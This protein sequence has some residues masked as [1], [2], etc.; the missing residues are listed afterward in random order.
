MP[1]LIKTAMVP[2]GTVLA[3]TVATNV[4]DAIRHGHSY[5]FTDDH[6]T[7]EVEARLHA[8]LAART[9]VVGA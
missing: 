1:G 2:I 4:V 6:Q 8:I 7:V 9:E 3:S 5:V